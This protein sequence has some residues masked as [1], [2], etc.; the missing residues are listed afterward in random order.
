MCKPFCNPVSPLVYVCV[1][2][3]NSGCYTGNK[4]VYNDLF[5]PN[6]SVSIFFKLLKNYMQVFSLSILKVALD[7]VAS[8][9]FV[10]KC[11]SIFVN[12]WNDINTQ[13]CCRLPGKR[14]IT[15]YFERA[16]SYLK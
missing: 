15:L 7:N 2:N 5:C 9:V 12:G 8:T 1:P 10:K 11:R 4:L 13:I 6:D 14:I 3:G 16:S